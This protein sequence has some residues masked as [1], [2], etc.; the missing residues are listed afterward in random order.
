MALLHRARGAPVALSLLLALLIGCVLFSGLANVAAKGDVLPTP[1]WSRYCATPFEACSTIEVYQYWEEKKNR[2][3]FTV[4]ALLKEPSSK[5]TLTIWMVMDDPDINVAKSFFREGIDVV[6]VHT[7][8]SH[9]SDSFMTCAKTSKPYDEQ[10]W[11]SEACA[12]ELAAAASMTGSPLNMSH[13]TADQ[14]AHDL[15]RA[16]R[17]LGNERFNVVLGQGLSSMLVLRFLQ[18]HQDTRAAV[19]LLDYVNPL[20]FDVYKYFGGSGM[21]VAL[22]HILA[23]CDDQVGCVGRLGA[24][25][26]SW[27]RLVAL[28]NRAKEG[29]LSCARRLKWGSN[30]GDATVFFDRLRAVLALMLRYPAYPFLR[31]KADLLSLIPS[32]LYRLQRCSDQDVAALNKLFDYL[33]GEKNYECPGSIP[34]QMHWLVNHFIS[35]A[36]PDNIGVFHKS[37]AASRLFLPA[38]RSLSSFHAAATKFPRIPRSAA[39]QVLPVNATQQILLLAADADALLPEGAASQ[40]ALAFHKLGSSVQVRQVRGIANQP[41]AMLTTCL[42]YNLKMLKEHGRWADEARCTLDSP[43][44]IDF[45]NSATDVY[46][47]TSDA[48]DFDKPNTDETDGGSGDDDSGGRSRLS[49]ILRF[50]FYGLLLLLLLGGIGA[51]GYFAYGYLRARGTFSYS[52]INDN[53]YENLHQ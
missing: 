40:L 29:K 4:D 39:S 15:N 14:A 35:E 20:K 34:L 37:A 44:Q 22:Q 17:T 30:K 31:S 48:W 6:I 46:Y 7:R 2:L 18:H 1:T 12:T 50:I 43:Y 5:D 27:H 47:G 3:N 38:L 52:R 8:G 32:F 16:L 23:L 51:G 21:D 49:A 53:F 25:E 11:M 24:T 26:G 33:G 13:Y 19:V 42:T 45:F 10:C 28:M 41:A 9:Q 36:A